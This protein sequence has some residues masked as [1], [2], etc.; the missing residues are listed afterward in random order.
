M[1]KKLSMI[2]ALSLA[3][4]AQSMAAEKLTF[5]TN[6]YE[7]AEHGGFYQA[8]AQNLYKDAGLDVTIKM[9]GP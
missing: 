2:A 5:M 9:G 7:Q 3:L 8:L 6:W 4:S 1:N